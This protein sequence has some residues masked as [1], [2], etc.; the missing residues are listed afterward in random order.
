MTQDSACESCWLGYP[1]NTR[2]KSLFYLYGTTPPGPNGER[3]PWQRTYPQG[4]PDLPCFDCV[5]SAKRFGQG[6]E[7]KGTEHTTLEVLETTDGN[8]SDVVGCQHVPLLD[9]GVTCFARDDATACRLNSRRTSAAD[10]HRDCFGAQRAVPS[11]KASRVPMAALRSG[12]LVLE[13]ENTVTRVVVN[14]HRHATGL[15]AA[16][17]TLHHLA[18]RL[19][20]TG[21]HVVHA[22]GRFIPARMVHRGTI[23]P[24]P[25]PS[26]PSSTSGLWCGGG[27]DGGRGLGGVGGWGKRW[28][29]SW[30]VATLLGCPRLPLAVSSYM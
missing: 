5:P 18:G 13:S 9:I 4:L 27:W 23:R 22:D 11:H 12:D 16:V 6:T 15:T 25:T 3:A 2:S 20:L 8:S 28:G 19:S 24:P 7:A 30:G 29:R 1:N 14:Q 21:S 10:A 26:H 17:L